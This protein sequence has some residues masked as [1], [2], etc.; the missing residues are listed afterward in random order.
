MRLNEFITPGYGEPVQR[1]AQPNYDHGKVIAHRGGVLVIQ[2]SMDDGST[3]EYE[4]PHAGDT[5][6]M[7][8]AIISRSPIGA[9]EDE[10]VFI[11]TIDVNTVEIESRGRGRP[12]RK[13]R[14]SPNAIKTLSQARA[15]Q[16]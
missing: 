7:P 5:P 4:M 11:R 13:E 16:G 8:G 6:L 15:E 12:D 9:G 14:V 10:V 3:F 1:L 2:G